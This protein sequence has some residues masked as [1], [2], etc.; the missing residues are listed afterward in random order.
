MVNT[1]L[2]K[3][4]DICN[5]KGFIIKE[6][7]RSGKY[8]EFPIYKV[9]I[10]NK[11]KKT[12]CI[13]AGSHGTEKSGPI[14]ALKFIKNYKPIKEDPRIIIFPL[15]NPDGFLKN[16]RKNYRD[17]DLNRHFFDDPKPK[18]IVK[19]INSVRKE[20]ID[21]FISLHE[22]DEKR[23]VYLYNYSK[24][25]KIAK[26]IINFFSKKTKICKDKKIYRDK[27]SSGI[28]SNPLHDGSFDEWM[29]NHR[30][31]TS[32]CIEI[33]DTILNSNQRNKLAYEFINFVINVF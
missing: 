10:N 28:I 32:I 31:K 30:V 18:E 13:S 33:P 29:F 17:I 5:K 26:K 23:G 21:L 4:R 9:I 7:S 20:K 15:L 2:T 12:I 22:D 19:I 3:L 1:Y 11:S 8:K 6:I 27:A 24:E 25:N 14:A 16:T